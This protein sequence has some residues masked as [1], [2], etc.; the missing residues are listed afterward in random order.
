MD[1]R[2]TKTHLPAAPCTSRPV[3]PSRAIHKESEKFL[4]FFQ[5]S[6]GSLKLVV[7]VHPSDEHP[8][9]VRMMVEHSVSARVPDRSWHAAEMV[10]MGYFEFIPY[11][12]HATQNRRFPERNGWGQFVQ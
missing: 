7:I 6:I 12:V 9:N 8:V 11:R 2:F 10:L 3:Q 1:G 4:M 5:Q